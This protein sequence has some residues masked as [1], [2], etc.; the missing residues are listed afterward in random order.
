[1]D[2]PTTKSLEGSMLILALLT[3]FLWLVNE[4]GR[5]FDAWLSGQNDNNAQRVWCAA[6][7]QCQVT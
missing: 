5:V 7:V 2:W 4:L 6:R 1:M 3:S